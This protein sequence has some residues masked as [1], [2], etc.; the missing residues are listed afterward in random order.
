VDPIDEVLSDRSLS[1]AQRQKRVDEFLKERGEEGIRI[2]LEAI[3]DARSE[4]SAAYAANFLAKQPGV[5]EGTN[6]AMLALLARE[7]RWIGAIASL[8]RFADKRTL[9]VL[10]ARVREHPGSPGAHSV[11]YRL[12]EHFPARTREHRKQFANHGLFDLLL[13]GAPDSWVRTLAKQYR[14]TRDGLV[15]IRLAKIGTDR[16]RE[17]LSKLASEATS[18]RKQF[19]A[20]LLKEARPPEGPAP[21]P[22]PAPHGIRERL[23]AATRKLLGGSSRETEG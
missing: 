21:S 5:E 22:S 14:R 6:N 8:V 19:F 12:A 4:V 3:A 1:G 16:A 13:P 18:S 2:A 17:A 23:L 9:E 20:A 10:V 15:A 11:A 7:P